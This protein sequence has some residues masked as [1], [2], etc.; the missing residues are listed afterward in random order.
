MF[1]LV[2]RTR[3]GT[4]TQYETCTIQQTPITTSLH[5][6]AE[7]MTTD[8]DMEMSTQELFSYFHKRQ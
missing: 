4:K 8:L 3:Y 2:Y 7:K 1:H 5:A 6:Q